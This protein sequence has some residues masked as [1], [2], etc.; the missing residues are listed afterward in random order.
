M[1]QEGKEVLIY[2]RLIDIATNIERSQTLYYFQM[3]YPTSHV[4]SQSRGLIMLKADEFESL[5][6]LF[7][8]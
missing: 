5:E 4:L 8:F 6:L 2:M 3:F 1:Q 7:E